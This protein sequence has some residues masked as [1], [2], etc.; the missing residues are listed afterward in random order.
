M[1]IE[2]YTRK[3]PPCPWCVKAK[4]RLKDFGSYT[5]YVVGTD[6]SREAFIEKFFSKV[7]NPR[8]TVPQIVIDGQHIGGY[9]KMM[10][11]I[12]SDYNLVM[13]RK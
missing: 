5:E 8:P 9:E 3:D 4:E 2:I 7:P 11:W 12:N 6:I 1:K 10:Q 13:E